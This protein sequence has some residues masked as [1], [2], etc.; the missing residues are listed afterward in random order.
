[1]ILLSICVHEEIKRRKDHWVGRL[2]HKKVTGKKNKQKKKQIFKALLKL[3]SNPSAIKLWE[4][5]QLISLE[6]SP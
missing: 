2:K 3:Q 1:M 4:Q 5:K 6:I